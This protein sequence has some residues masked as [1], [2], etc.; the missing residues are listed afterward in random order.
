VINCIIV[1][2]YFTA[3]IYA[4]LHDLADLLGQCTLPLLVLIA[5]I[6]IDAGIV[7]GA[8]LLICL[9]AATIFAPIALCIYG[10]CVFTFY[11]WNE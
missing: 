7:A 6:F 4:L 5:G 9:G 1:L 2:V 11:N 3:I 10:Y 8:P